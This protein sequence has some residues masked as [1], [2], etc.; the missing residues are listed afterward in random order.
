MLDPEEV[1]KHYLPLARYLLTLPWRDSRQVIAIAGP[2]GCGKSSFSAVLNRVINL[3]SRREICTVVGQ[4]GWHYPNHYL[5]SHLI[6]KGNLMIPL[7]QI[8]GAPETFDVDGL[9]ACL[10]RIKTQDEISFPIYSRVEHEPLPEAG[11]IKL[12]HRIILFEGIY[13]LLDRPGWRDIHAMVDRSIFLTTPVN[14]LIAGLRER[15]LRGGKDPQS[16]ENH[17]RT[18]DLPDIQLVMDFSTSADIQVEK[19][20]PQ[21]ITRI[22]LP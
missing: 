7:R 20:D 3:L 2:P 18:V 22:I 4:D 1:S 9:L 5:A 15:H 8:K 11:Q 12:E 6:Q 16:V 14:A 10:N 19:A 13:L 21:R 17:L